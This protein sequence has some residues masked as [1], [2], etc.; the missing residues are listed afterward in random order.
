VARPAG[1]DRNPGAEDGNPGAAGW[2]MRDGPGDP[3]GWLDASY[4][5]YRS[6]PVQARHMHADYA[7][8][9]RVYRGAVIRAAGAGAT[10]IRASMSLVELAR[11][12]PHL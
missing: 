6:L 9:G 10:W 4:D 1:Q 8:A 7:A 5:P 12:S 3:A 2:V 11:V